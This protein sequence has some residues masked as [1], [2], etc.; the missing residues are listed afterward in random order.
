RGED[1]L[2]V[3]QER[4]ARG[5]HRRPPEPQEPRPPAA[6]RQPGARPP[7]PGPRGEP[8]GRG[9]PHRAQQRKPEARA[10]VQQPSQPPR[11]HAAHQRLCHRRA[12]A[13]Q[14]SSQQRG[15]DARRKH[16]CRG[17]GGAR[18]RRSVARAQR[19]PRLATSLAWATAPHSPP[20]DR[21]T[22]TPAHRTGT[23]TTRFGVLIVI[24]S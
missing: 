5:R 1:A 7:R 24:T 2:G 15:A 10:Q 21:H 13:E 22:G 12:C 8:G 19:T 23:A 4:G 16:E 17:C 3:Q 18:H 9:A 20:G 14:G 6:A 11:P